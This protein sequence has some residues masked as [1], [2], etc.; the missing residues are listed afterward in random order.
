MNEKRAG[1][2]DKLSGHC[3]GW[4]FEL[5]KLEIQGDGGGG[6]GGGGRCFC[7]SANFFTYEQTGIYD[8]PKRHDRISGTYLWLKSFEVA[9]CKVTGCEELEKNNGVFLSETSQSLPKVR[10]S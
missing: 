3:Q 5:E 10:L 8:S 4:H 1:G 2:G 7:P 9:G 6:A